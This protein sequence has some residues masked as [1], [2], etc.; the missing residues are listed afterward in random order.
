VSRK[1]GRP[2]NATITREEFARLEARVEELRR[3]FHLQ[4]RRIAQIQAE[5]DQIQGAW[6]ERKGELR[7][8]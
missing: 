7:T 4:F 1:D 5:L 3:E 2:A 8:R 6:S